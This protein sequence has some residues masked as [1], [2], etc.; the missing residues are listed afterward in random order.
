MKADDKH[1]E[2]VI[3]NITS[4][5]A[6]ITAMTERSL[7]DTKERISTQGP[8]LGNI[9]KVV[10]SSAAIIEYLKETPPQ[11]SRSYTDQEIDDLNY[12]QIQKIIFASKKA[13]ISLPSE[14]ISTLDEITLAAKGLA[15]D[16]IS[17]ILNFTH[18][19]EIPLSPE[20]AASSYGQRTQNIR[21]A[22]NRLKDNQVLVETAG[23]ARLVLNELVYQVAGYK[24]LPNTKWYQ[25][26]Q[27]Y[28]LAAAGAPP[29]II[30]PL[31]DRDV[32]EAETKLYGPKAKEIVNV[33]IQGIEAAKSG[34]ITLPLITATAKLAYAAS[35]GYYNDELKRVIIDE[36]QHLK[37][38][39]DGQNRTNKVLKQH[40]ELQEILDLKIEETITTDPDQQLA[41]I[42]KQNPALR[43]IFQSDDSQKFASVKDKIIFIQ[44]LNKLIKT[45][46]HLEG[47]NKIWQKDEAELSEKKLKI[48]KLHFTRIY[49]NEL[50]KYQGERFSQQE[51]NKLLMG[52]RQG[53]ISKGANLLIEGAEFV[54]DPSTKTKEKL[55]ATIS[56]GIFSK[57]T[58]AYVEEIQKDK[59]LRDNTLLRMDVPEY[60]L[61]SGYKHDLAKT[62]F[63]KQVEALTLEEM[64]QQDLTGKDKLEL[65]S[66]YESTKLKVSETLKQDPLFSEAILNPTISTKLY[67]I[68]T[69]L[70]NSANPWSQKT[71]LPKSKKK[72]AKPQTEEP[73]KTEEAAPLL[74][75][76]DNKE[77]NPDS[78]SI[79][80]SSSRGN[81]FDEIIPLELRD[82]LRHFRN[83][84]DTVTRPLS[85]DSVIKLES[86]PHT[87]IL[88]KQE[89][90][91]GKVITK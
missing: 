41:E 15:T 29:L 22:V 7:K 27:S 24:P 40:P 90:T 18:G 60:E 69:G 51:Q 71:K 31:L 35:V 73:I 64:A 81:S 38:Y 25:D 43:N 58:K 6:N 89:F 20:V 65:K 87:P 79:S 85:P 48:A 67:E 80:P 37:K 28:S 62:A 47:S 39:I 57:S 49:K 19:V 66:I 13:E 88:R 5:A 4:T 56:G 17:P 68:G 75:S 45:N 34:A 2:L 26:T 74:P 11:V 32:H 61:G 42:Y 50:K 77:V 59:I 8:V 53:L 21:K 63:A 70:L 12:N 3:S 46:D 83:S 44:T 55:E 76:G 84:P 33:L 16:V 30:N 14:P 91:K 52:L 86:P 82:S 1:E 10:S 78:P 36:N 23:V 9:E 54:V 72:E